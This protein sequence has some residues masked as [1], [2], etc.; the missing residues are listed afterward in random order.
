MVIIS[1]IIGALPGPGFII[2]FPVGLALLLK[3]SRSAKKIYA[4]FKRRFP[5]YGKWADWAMRRN[6]H[7]SLPENFEL[8][9]LGKIKTG[10]QDNSV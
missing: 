5:N 10:R 2:I 8:P 4:N 1:P 6:R 9:I 3:N 7:R